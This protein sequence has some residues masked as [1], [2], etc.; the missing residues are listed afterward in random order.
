MNKFF[1]IFLLLKF[2]N[3]FSGAWDNIDLSDKYWVAVPICDATMKPI[4]AY[5][6]PVSAEIVYDSC[7]YSMHR[8]L[9]YCPRIN[10]LLINEVVTKKKDH[11]L[12][13][14]F[15]VGNAIY[16]DD[17]GNDL[18]GFCTLKKNLISLQ[19]LKNAGIDLS[20]IPDPEITNIKDQLLLDF[21]WKES[22][23]KN[24]FFCWH[25]I[26]KRAKIRF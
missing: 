5:D 17:S 12:E 19:E 6:L 21:Y 11:P 16:K 18:S 20:L 25:K 22:E 9:K 13:M 10:Q 15:N 14:E 23:N 7:P 4:V 3:L 24:N 8:L 2:F 1:S 26:C